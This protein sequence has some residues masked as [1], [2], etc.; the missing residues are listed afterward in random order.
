VINHNQLYYIFRALGTPTNI[1]SKWSLSLAKSS[2]LEDMLDEVIKAVDCQEELK[3]PRSIVPEDIEDYAINVQEKTSFDMKIA[4]NITDVQWYDQV[5]SELGLDFIYT[6]ESDWIQLT[7]NYEQYLAIYNTTKYLNG[8]G[9][10]VIEFVNTTTSISRAW[11]SNNQVYIVDEIDSV[12]GGVLAFEGGI[13]SETGPMP[14]HDQTSRVQNRW[15]DDLNESFVA[16]DFLNDVTYKIVLNEDPAVLLEGVKICLHLKVIDSAPPEITRYDYFNQMIVDGETLILP[17]EIATPPL[18]TAQV[19]SY[20]SSFI[21][22]FRSV[23]TGKDLPTFQ[24][25]LDLI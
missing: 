4:S 23:V 16:I 11:D 24:S 21:S 6:D 7:N 17:Q 20:T 5:K 22:D 25:V 3:N 18:A 8:G 15:N 1:N 12:S 10:G 13:I 2:K 9:F 19:L 14:N